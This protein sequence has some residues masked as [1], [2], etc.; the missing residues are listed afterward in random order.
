MIRHSRQAGSCLQRALAY[1][2]VAT[3]L[4]SLGSMYFKTRYMRQVQSM[5]GRED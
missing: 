3:T 5:I 4:L 1:I 2:V